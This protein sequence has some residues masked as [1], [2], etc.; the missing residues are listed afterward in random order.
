MRNV[1]RNFPGAF[2]VGRSLMSDENVNYLS[3]LLAN[4]LVDPFV[5]ATFE[6]DKMMNQDIREKIIVN[7]YRT[8]LESAKKKEKKRQML[9]ADRERL[10]KLVLLRNRQYNVSIILFLCGWCICIYFSL[11][12]RVAR[13]SAYEDHRSEFAEFATLLGCDEF[14]DQCEMSEEES[15]EG[16][17]YVRRRPA[18]RS[19]KV[20]IKYIY[21]LNMILIW[22]ILGN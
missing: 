2:N 18:Y 11:K 1:A 15:Y 7:Y 9:T 3:G 16:R 22:I 4:A 10:E 12:L 5:L 8:N 14:L 6:Q 21:D 19:A 17:T 13:K 20:D